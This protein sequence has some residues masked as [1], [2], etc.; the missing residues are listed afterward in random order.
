MRAKEVVKHDKICDGTLY[1]QTKSIEGMVA[2]TIKNQIFEDHNM[3]MLM[4]IS[5]S[6]T[7][8]PQA[9]DCLC[10]RQAEDFKNLQQYRL[11]QD[12]KH[13]EQD[14]HDFLSITWY[15]KF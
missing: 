1:V 5:K 15:T 9:Q 10:P 2:T 6:P 12:K 3:L 11:A 13:E 7:L 4:T 14:K 8:S